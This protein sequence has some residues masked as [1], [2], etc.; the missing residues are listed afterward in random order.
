MFGE[1][2]EETRRQEKAVFTLSTNILNR[3]S[4]F[5]ESAEPS[6]LT[7]TLS[8][9]VNTTKKIAEEKDPVQAQTMVRGCFIPWKPTR[10][11]KKR[12]N[13]APSVQRT[14]AKTTN[15]VW[16]A[17]RGISLIAVGATIIFQEKVSSSLT[18]FG[19]APWI[20]TQCAKTVI[21]AG[22]SDLSPYSRG[23]ERL[24]N[25]VKRTFFQKLCP[26]RYLSTSEH[27]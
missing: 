13:P 1:K 15:V 5:L 22:C 2:W 10:F 18:K 25:S 23:K 19:V 20:L 8:S 21:M 16:R 12:L 27:L 9:L 6:E 14:A 4:S 17:L 11:R 7:K 26:P 3:L 24:S